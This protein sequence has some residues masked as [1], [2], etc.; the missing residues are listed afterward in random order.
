VREVGRLEADE[1]NGNRRGNGPFQ[2][3][4]GVA[5]RV[6]VFVDIGGMCVVHT[7]SP[8]PIDDR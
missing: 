7:G 3:G 4:Y 6:A 2:V 1:G 8:M 5:H